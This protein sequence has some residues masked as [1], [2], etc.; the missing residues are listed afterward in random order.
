MTK[1]N[2]KMI[3][4]VTRTKYHMLKAEFHA[5][6]F[7]ACL[8]YTHVHKNLFNWFAEIHNLQNNQYLVIYNNFLVMQLNKPFTITKSN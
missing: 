2:Y 1:V 4:I 3:W 7:P 5:L 6:H 8:L